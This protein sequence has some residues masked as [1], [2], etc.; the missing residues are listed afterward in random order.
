VLAAWL[1]ETSFNP[2]ISLELLSIFFN[3]NFPGQNYWQGPFFGL[4][5][6]WA[7]ATFD[8]KKE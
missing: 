2:A 7:S 1:S 3:R 6:Q 4:W 5:E 8:N